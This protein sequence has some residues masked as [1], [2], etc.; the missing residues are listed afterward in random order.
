MTNIK[1]ILI[2][3]LLFLIGSGLLVGDFYMI[4]S[5]YGFLKSSEKTEGVVTK[6][7]SNRSSDGKIMYNPEISF[8]DVSGKVIIFQSSLSSTIPDYAVGEK[9]SV[10]YDKTNPQ[11]AK[12]NTFLQLWFG[13]MIMTVLGAV[14]FLIGLFTLLDKNRKTRLEII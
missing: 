6:L 9:V 5:T 4:K 14:F 7:I 2:G 12:I 8:S 13:P 1:A 11:K 10:L 3:L